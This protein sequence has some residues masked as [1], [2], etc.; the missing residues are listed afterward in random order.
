MFQCKQLLIHAVPR[1][2]QNNMLQSSTAMA[3]YCP[4][5]E[6][7]QQ[8]QQWKKKWENQTTC[9]L[10]MAFGTVVHKMVYL[11]EGRKTLGQEE[12]DSLVGGGV[13]RHR[14]GITKMDEE[15]DTQTLQGMRVRSEE[16]VCREV[17]VLAMPVRPLYAGIAFISF[18]LSQPFKILLLAQRRVPT[19]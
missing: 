9:N 4:G 8:Q 5:L 1:V 7:Q 19:V 10:I 3:L 14:C 2:G 17:L 13:V 18:E 11:L 15:D 6:Q 12:M 16:V